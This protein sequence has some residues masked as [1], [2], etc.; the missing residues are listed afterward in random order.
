MAKRPN[1]FLPGSAVFVCEDCGRS[2]RITHQPIGTTCCYECWEIAGYQNSVYDGD[3]P[4][5]VAPQVAA[6]A[7]TIVQRGGDLAKLRTEYPE[8]FAFINEDFTCKTAEA[9]VEFTSSEQE[10][11][12]QPTLLTELNAF[13]SPAEVA[14][15]PRKAKAATAVSAVEPTKVVPATRSKFANDDF[16]VVLVDECPKRAGTK[17]AEWWA[18]Q[19][20]VETVGA[21]KAAGVPAGDLLWN[22]KHGFIVV[23]PA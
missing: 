13:F 2:T 20:K 21:A 22:V 6:L 23:L 1:N 17:A 9:P 12:M 8:I 18:K 19:A 16:I 3:K 10:N 15:K 5:K 7:K 14:A 11:I 4:Q